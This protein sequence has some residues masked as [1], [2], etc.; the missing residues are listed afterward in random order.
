MLSDINKENC[1]TRKTTAISQPSFHARKT[2][3]NPGAI[4]RAEYR[5]SQTS[6]IFLHVPSTSDSATVAE[7][8]KGT[9][10]AVPLKDAQD[11]PTE[12]YN[13]ANLQQE[14]AAEEMVGERFATASIEEFTRVKE[15]L[16]VVHQRLVHVESLARLVREKVKQLDG[17]SQQMESKVERLHE[18]LDE[19]ESQ[20]TERLETL[21]HELVYVTE[22]I[23]RH[24][25]L[26][27]TILAET[28][29][30]TKARG[31]HLLGWVTG[32]I[33]SFDNCLATIVNLGTSKVVP[34]SDNCRSGTLT[35]K[36]R[37]T[38]SNLLSVGLMI[39]AVFVA[40][41]WWHKRH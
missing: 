12:W 26:I 40:H 4:T 17:I 6:S 10:G 22:A 33:A 36:Y 41:A 25:E 28:K 35:R 31:F 16:E 5:E 15:K 7:S 32:K 39:T 30:L 29:I 21:D 1:D 18:R 14:I 19:S 24:E 38:S 27:D 9:V 13:E 8:G 37:D 2:N 23:V 20:S 34:K 3:P 11:I